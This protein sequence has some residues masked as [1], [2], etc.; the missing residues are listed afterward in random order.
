ME[1][2]VVERLARRMEFVTA[3]CSCCHSRMRKFR[4]KCCTNSD[5]IRNLGDR[6]VNPATNNVNLPLELFSLGR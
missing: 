5:W 1:G 2:L 4:M 3:L 6:D